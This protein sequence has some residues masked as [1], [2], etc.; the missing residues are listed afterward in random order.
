MTLFVHGTRTNNVNELWSYGPEAQSILVKFD[1]LRYRLF[2][3]IYSLAWRV[4]HDS[5][6]LMRPLVMDF[7]NDAVAINVGDQFMF[8]PA[9]L[10]NPVT[11][12]DANSRELYLPQG[13]WYDL[14]SGEKT[15]GGRRLTA[16]APLDRIPLYVRAGSIVPLG[17]DLEYSTEKPAD[18]IE[19][20]VFPGAD[21]D[22]ALYED[23][24]DGYDYEKG[25]HATIP[26]HW[27]D[28]GRTLTIG[29]R[30][31]SFPGML[32]KRTFHV[33]F[34]GA[35]RGAGIDPTP[36]PDRVIEYSGRAIQVQR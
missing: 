33:V 26:V 12:A 29:E 17:P 35:G 24:N 18:P 14:W 13:E 16:P 22:F 8:G 25:I 4:N 31:G 7:P 11:E 36:E 15:S 1:R 30:Q 21:G 6:T 5:Y 9:V 32:E 23:E 28:A 10:V 2:P 20:R 19:L 34:V 3:Y 27:N